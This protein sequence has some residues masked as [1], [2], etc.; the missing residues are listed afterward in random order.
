MSMSKIEKPNLWVR[1]TS[2][3]R[4]GRPRH[5]IHMEV[6][7]Q[8]APSRVFSDGA[9]RLYDELGNS[10]PSRSSASSNLKA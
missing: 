5:G 2:S 1:I 6:R 3:L 10:V 8:V 4:D 7:P 9:G